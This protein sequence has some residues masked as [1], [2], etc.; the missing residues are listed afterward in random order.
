M[1]RGEI[2]FEG[3]PSDAFANQEVMRTIRG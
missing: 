2:L 1:D 3:T